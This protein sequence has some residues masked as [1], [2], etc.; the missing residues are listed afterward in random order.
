MSKAE[1]KIND[2]VRHTYGTWRRQELWKSPLLIKD[3][4]GVYIYD[5]GGK[6]YIDF[7]SQLMCSNLGHKNKVVIEAI[8]K[9]AERLPYVSPGFTTEASVAAIKALR[10][11]L[12]EELQK[13]FFS[14]SGTEANEAALKIVR[15][16][17]APSYKILSRYH[18][19]H[20]ATPGS[21]TFTGDPRRILAE[22]ARCTIDGVR[23][24]PDAYCYRCPFNLTYPGCGIQCVRYVDYMFKEEGNV[25]GIIVEPIV[26]TNGRIV[27]P[28]E[29]FPMLREI[30]DENDVLL[31]ADEVMSGWFRTGKAFAVEHWNVIPDILTTAK[32]CTA[33]YT[34]AGVT[35]T[36]REIADFFEQEP[37]DH[38][39][40]YAYHP[41][42]LSAIPAAVGEYKRL[43]QTGLPQR[44]SK[45][46]KQRLY[47]LGDRHQSIGDVR[48]MGHFWALELVRDR[49]TKEPFNVKMDKFGR[50][51]LMTSKVAGDAMSGGVYV[52]AWYDTLIIAPPL[53]I[54]QDEVD[55]AIDIIDKSLLIADREAVSTDIP[56]S[57]TSEFISI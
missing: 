32:G 21:I 26:G 20:G 49:K 55:E 24:A 6:R 46:L 37:F 23:F 48:G 34:P 35:V 4:E 25:A 22:R 39:H 17:K 16:Y 31:I 3:A 15:Q 51:P 57:K 1:Q 44:V 29:Y 50:K 30:C 36:T 38:G 52:A 12:P 45:H 19:Y 11:V 9:Q 43:M 2:L 40:T 33:A 56:V 27:P 7:S 54:T 10:S 5:D 13:F 18:S 42:V 53:I 41:L 47:E 8:I 28:P 14:T